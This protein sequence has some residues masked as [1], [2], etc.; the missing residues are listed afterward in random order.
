MTNMPSSP[1]PD[2]TAGGLPGVRPGSGAMFDRIARRYDL[3]NRLMS[4][5]LD[6]L[7]RRRTVRSLALGGEPSKVLD[8]ATG[9]ADLA[10]ETARSENRTQVVGIDPSAE[11]LAVGRRKITA[12]G[13]DGRIELRTGSAESLPFDDDSVDGVTIAWGIRN[14]ADRPAALREMARVT[15]PGGRVAILEATEARGL[16]GRPAR[17]YVHHVVPRIGAL[18]SGAAEYRYLQS[19]IEAFPPPEDFA[20]MM[21]QNGLDIVEVVPMI[22]GVTHLFVGTPTVSENPGGVR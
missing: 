1:N 3:I 6:I 15:R 22:A 9:T 12:A 16:L 13:L 7:W 2:I 4:G 17:F 8:L 18:L 21:R 5:G 14:V 10:L 20:D 19:S 11:M